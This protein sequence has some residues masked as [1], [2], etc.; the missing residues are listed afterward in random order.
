MGSPTVHGT[1]RISSEEEIFGENCWKLTEMVD[2]NVMLL[3]SGAMSK[4]GTNLSPAI[5]TT[6]IATFVSQKSFQIVARL[7]KTSDGKESLTRY[8]KIERIENVQDDFFLPPNDFEK[9]TPKTFQEYADVLRYFASGHRRADDLTGTRN[10]STRPV[11]KRPISH[12]ES[13][14]E[15]RFK[16]LLVFFVCLSGLFALCKLF[17]SR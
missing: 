5:V 12:S 13:S 8:S 11:T 9:M 3:T 15:F 6:E 4:L 10:L 7:A 1:H 16:V 17:A 2:K 14:V